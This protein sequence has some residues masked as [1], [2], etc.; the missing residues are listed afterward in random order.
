MNKVILANQAT[1][2]LHGTNEEAER[3][4]INSFKDST[5]RI[6]QA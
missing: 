4:A 6:F 3:I 5:E 1:S 2:M